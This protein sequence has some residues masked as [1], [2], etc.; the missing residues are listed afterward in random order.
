M[1]R[2]VYFS[3]IWGAK[4]SGRCEVYTGALDCGV[5]FP[6]FLDQ[7]Q[8]QETL[9]REM[10]NRLGVLD[11]GASGK[12][13]APMQKLLCFEVYL[14]CEEQ[15]VNGQRHAVPLLP[16]RSMCEAVTEL[17][18][19]VHKLAHQYGLFLEYVAN[20]D[21]T[22]GHDDSKIQLLSE[23]VSQRYISYAHPVGYQGEPAFPSDGRRRT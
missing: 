5:D 2:L 7:N 21:E 18:A 15:E 13:R 11:Q 10:E 3:L 19:T 1:Q 9:H 22:S 16:C 8:V 17:C 14:P 23:E 4:A 12:C 6:I 20:C